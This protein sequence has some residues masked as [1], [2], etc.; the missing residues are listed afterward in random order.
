MTKGQLLFLCVAGVGKDAPLA[1]LAAHSLPAGSTIDDEQ[2]TLAD[3]AG[4]KRCRRSL[5][6]EMKPNSP[7]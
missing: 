3:I 7:I 2:E 4:C 6:W 1:D 5:L